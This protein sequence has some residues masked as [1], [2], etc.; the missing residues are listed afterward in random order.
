MPLP[1]PSPE[2]VRELLRYDPETG[3]FFRRTNVG[4]AKAGDETGATQ[5]RYIM[6]SVDNRRYSAHRLA[7]VCMTGE[8]PANDI[9][10]KNC[11]PSDNR[12]VNL[13]AATESQNLANQRLSKNNKSGL[14]G[15]CWENWSGRWLAQIM[16]QRRRINLG[17]FDDK[18]EAHM[19]YC[20]AAIR[21]FGAYART[22]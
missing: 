11:D 3:R 7:W 12:W 5:R 22:E 15:V 21:Y 17:R 6:I 16:V 2:R 8:W 9:D 14:K 1:R 20:A 4:P 13:R 19:A 18:H 10:H